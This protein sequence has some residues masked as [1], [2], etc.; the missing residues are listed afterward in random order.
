MLSAGA[1]AVLL[2]LIPLAPALAQTPATGSWHE[3]L[4]RL[5]EA[6]VVRPAPGVEDPRPAAP[7]A[8]VPEPPPA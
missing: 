3:E 5:S 7:A 2:A 6:S 1:V 4:R 8:A